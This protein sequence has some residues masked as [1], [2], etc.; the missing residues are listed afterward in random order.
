VF[1]G[2]TK[3]VVVE[4]AD[5]TTEEAGEL[6][7]ENFETSTR[8]RLKTKGI[9]SREDAKATKKTSFLFTF[10]S[11]SPQMESCHRST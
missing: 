11:P 1:T 9:I 7:K 10:S 6:P 4:E 3:T 2:S 8:P 5:A